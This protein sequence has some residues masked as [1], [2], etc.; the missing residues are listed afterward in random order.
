MKTFQVT[1]LVVVR[2]RDFFARNLRTNE[3]TT[4]LSRRTKS[5]IFYL[6]TN[7]S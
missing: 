2:T 1:A 5:Q 6:R 7:C 3:N 4:N